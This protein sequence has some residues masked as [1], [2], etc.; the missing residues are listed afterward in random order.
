M[1]LLGGVCA[2]AMLFAAP[3]A[4]AANVAVQSTTDIFLASQPVGT[5]ITGYFGSDSVTTNPATNNAPVQIGVAGGN[6]LTFSASGSTSVDD[7]CF[8]GPDGGCYGDESSFSPSPAGGTYKGPSDAL[9]GVF[10]GNGVTTVANG[11]PSLN[12]TKAANISRP[13]Y[14]PGLNQ[15]FFIG[16]GLTGTGTGSTQDFIAP[17]GATNLYIAV[18]DSYG[19]STGNEGSLNVTYNIGTAAVPEPSTWAVMAVGLLALGAMTRNARRKQA[20]VA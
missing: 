4:F 11:P 18:A 13:A 8:A 6:V 15:I 20:L 19:S 10:L 1:K 7:S 16:D 3:A 12:Y 9:I 17:A 14:H 2:A 5:T